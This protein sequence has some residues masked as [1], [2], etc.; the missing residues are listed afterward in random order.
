MRAHHFSSRS[1]T[2]YWLEKLVGAKVHGSARTR[3]A[4]LRKPPRRPQEAALGPLLTHAR[5]TRAVVERRRSGARHAAQHAARRPARQGRAARA[6]AVTQ[7]R[8]Q[9][10]RA[11]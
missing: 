1:S 6:P 4:P 9:G 11:H 5:R 2:K 7:Q 3:P 10:A 8:M